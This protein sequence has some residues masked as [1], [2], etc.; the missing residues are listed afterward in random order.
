ML[1]LDLVGVGQV[2]EKACE[3]LNG[4]GGDRHTVIGLLQLSPANVSDEAVVIQFEALPPGLHRG[5]VGN[6]IGQISLD[7]LGIFRVGDKRVLAHAVGGT[8]VVVDTGG[9]IGCKLHLGREVEPAPGGVP[10]TDAECQRLG[11]FIDIFLLDILVSQAEV[12]VDLPAYESFGQVVA[13]NCG[14]RQQ[15]DRGNG[16]DNL[17]T[18]SHRLTPLGPSSTNR[19]HNHSNQGPMLAPF[20]D[21]ERAP[22]RP[23]N[24][25]GCPQ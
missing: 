9:G 24:H 23:G 8:V 17:R 22:G 2:G 19:T 5:V 25:R 18:S 21:L 13:C 4:C 12:G 16:Q 1:A 10:E 3:L 14:N 7:H 11:F 6:G 15:H 20:H